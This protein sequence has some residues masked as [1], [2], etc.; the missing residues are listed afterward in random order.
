MF[1]GLPGLG[2]AAAR[3]KPGGD[4]RNPEWRVKGNSFA[5]PVANRLH[6]PSKSRFSHEIVTIG[7]ANFNFGS[8]P[9]MGSVGGCTVN[10]IRPSSSSEKPG[11][12]A[13]KMEL[14]TKNGF[15]NLTNMKV[16]H[17]MRRISDSEITAV[18]LDTFMRRMSAE[19]VR[20]S[21]ALSSNSRSCVKN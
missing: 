11:T 6:I 1:L 9:Q 21:T 10:F 3:L 7:W 18:N 2:A 15:V 16:T 5:P 4:E 12:A 14:K 8:R 17:W 13:P 19:P 20:K